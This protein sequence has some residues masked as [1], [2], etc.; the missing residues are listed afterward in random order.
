LRRI[1]DGLDADPGNCGLWRQAGEFLSRAGQ[2]GDAARCFGVA[3]Q[4]TGR[5]S[6]AE[7]GN[8]RRPRIA[9][10]CG[11]DGATF[12]RDIY[13]FAATRF[14]VRTFDGSTS[15]DVFELMKWSDIS[16]FEWCTEFA[17]I[18]SKLPK[19]CKNIVRL[20]RY[21]AYLDWPKKVNWN[22]VDRLITV[23][24]SFVN[25]E[26]TA[27]VPDINRRCR[28]VTIPNGV[29]L[30]KFKFDSR[31]SRDSRPSGKNIAFVANIR[32]VKG[33]MLLAQCMQRLLSIDGDYNLYIAGKSYDAAL[34]QYLRHIVAAMGMSGLVFFDGWQEDIVGWLAD[35]HYIVSTSMIESQGMGVL[36]AMAAGLKPVV[37]NF[38]GSEGTF[39]KEWLFNTA[40]EFCA[41]IV[42][43]DY[44]PMRYRQFVEE[45]YP[46]SSQ[47]DSIGSMFSELIAEIAAAS[48]P[49]E[50][51]GVFSA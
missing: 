39:G 49:A 38:P 50:G 25:Q 10:F 20:H 44:Q 45:R 31:G 12:L 17:E 11:G 16:W 19:V 26:L 1:R 43:G 48:P 15:D 32:P 4:L 9:F 22:N 27:Q 24:N 6:A 21:E 46:L 14:D 8:G 28:I 23:G 42:N 30:E 7:A 18:G 37:H 40:D 36:E 34:E 47:L 2:S 41:Q 5:G 13:S 3:E 51:L 35:K 33:P 29:D